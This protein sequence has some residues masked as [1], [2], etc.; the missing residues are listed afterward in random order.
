MAGGDPGERGTGPY[1]WDTQMRAQGW[2]AGFSLSFLHLTLGIYLPWQIHQIS[3]HAIKIHHIKETH[4]LKIY[5]KNCS[6]HYLLVLNET[7]IVV[8]NV[9]A[10][11]FTRHSQ[12]NIQNWRRI[13]LFFMC[14]SLKIFSSLT[15][16]KL[17]F[18]VRSE[19]HLLRI[20]DCLWPYKKTPP[21]AN[22]L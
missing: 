13:C 17:N 11:V 18:L 10:G 1:S 9:H 12:I 5:T 21:L 20:A 4:L 19:W 15:F 3:G 2:A 8:R 6:I 16:M 22:D 14:L 7:D